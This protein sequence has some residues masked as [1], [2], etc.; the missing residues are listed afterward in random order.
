ME[1]EKGDRY[2][3]AKNTKKIQTM[4]DTTQ[5]LNQSG[6]LSTQA[7]Y[8]DLRST[9]TAQDVFKHTKSKQYDNS[10]FKVSAKA[11]E[12]LE[13]AQ[14]TLPGFS[15]QAK[16]IADRPSH[17]RIPGDGQLNLSEL[18]QW[19]QE[20][21]LNKKNT[22]T[23]WKVS[24][25]YTASRSLTRMEESKA[26][27][28]KSLKLRE[29]IAS[30]VQTQTNEVHTQFDNRLTVLR[31]Y[32]RDET[33]L[34]NALLQEVEG[35]RIGIAEME[36]WIASRTKWPIKVNAECA[37]FRNQ[38]IGIDLVLDDLE[39]EL[40]KEQDMLTTLIKKN[41]D[42]VLADAYACK[43][44]MEE[45]ARLLL[46]DINRKTSTTTVDAKMQKLKLIEVDK[47][48]NMATSIN[49]RPK[50]AIRTEDWK[51]ISD[52][53]INRAR[54]AMQGCA[55]LHTSLKAA[56]RDSEA[57]IGEM[58][59]NVNELL[60]DK[61]K[62][63]KAQTAATQN[64][65]SDTQAEVDALET[66]IHLVERAIE[67]GEGPLLRATTQLETRRSRPSAEK[68]SDCAH[69]A[70]IQ[71]VAE[72]HAAMNALE[73]QLET[74]M[75]NFEELKREEG[76]LEEELAIKKLTVVLEERC[77]KIRKFLEPTA[78]NYMVVK[79][80]NDD[81]FCDLLTR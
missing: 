19:Y 68:T 40:G 27:R 48:A 67:D 76:A 50:S 5:N 30:E 56:V 42:Q 17:A 39:V 54:V 9:D 72:L 34:R 80:L 3:N 23:E 46:E 75:K 77:R 36:A 16:V 13:V 53:L 12:A 73:S 52:A 51:E 7:L 63:S 6:L 59:D 10:D 24:A 32:I 47:E 2:Q 65:L 62:S 78:D 69:D 4:A 61:I 15:P 37:K 33:D 25:D 38:R 44:D 14:C 20:R 11:P 58:S 57:A 21:K 81:E 29:D 28:A 74:H 60:D 71:E 49:I 26:A 1:N 79:M 55:D 22:L 35:M 70:L 41:C 31:D 66:E 8:N 45:V 18:S 64:L 43:A